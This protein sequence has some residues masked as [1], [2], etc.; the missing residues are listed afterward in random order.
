MSD[1]DLD[2]EEDLARRSLDRKTLLRLA[3]L[4][5]PVWPLLLGVM[6]FATIL[7]M[8]VFTRPY[9]IEWTIDDGLLKQDDGSYLLK[10]D[11]L[12]L[13]CLGLVTVWLGRFLALIMSK[14]FAGIMAF[15]I[16]NDLRQQLFRHVHSLSMRFFDKT[17]VGRIVSRADSDV[18]HLEMAVIEG[19]VV[20]YTTVIRFTLASA[21]LYWY[22]PR[23][24]F[25]LIPI[26]PCMLIAMFLFQKFGT[27]LWAKITEARSRV[28]AHLVETI[29]GIRVIK[30]FAQEQENRHH[31]QDRLDYL[32]LRVRLAAYGW[33][34]FFP[35]LIMLFMCGLCIV[36]WQGGLALQA[37]ELTV[38]EFTTCVFYVF[39]FLGPLADLGMLY[40]HLA[41]GIAS[42][43]RIFL[44]LDT[45]PEVVDHPQAV[46]LAQVTGD[47]VY[48]NVHFYYNP[49][50]WVLHGI[51]LEVPAGQNLAIVGPTGHGKS[52]L[53]QLLAR[54]Y[55]I[56]EG[57][58]TIDGQDI[59][60]VTQQSLHKHVG[61]VLQDN[62]LFSGT[63][64]DNLRLAQPH[65]SDDELIAA[66]RELCADEVIERLPDQY[67]TEVGARGDF[68]SHGQRQLVCL[69]RAY[70]AD[71][72]ILVLDEATSSIDVYTEQ[73]VQ[74]ALWR[75][76]EGRTAI[77]I[78]HRLATIRD[79][80]RIIV[81]NDGR[82]VE[83]G[84]H[85]ELL[86]QSGKYADLYAA[87]QDGD[88]IE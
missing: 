25:A 44:L 75:L 47:I 86:A 40:E 35:F 12:V 17:K 46:P 28:T 80:D 29:G 11:V 67:H 55:D 19:P 21:V 34:W 82:I 81:I 48:K 85:D 39:L 15:R 61:V 38:G 77:I 8:C 27:R 51:N 13:M 79:A 58:I 49:E 56:Q 9:F 20:A 72:A 37:E 88:V 64:L 42:A 65:A 66:C 23:I 4:V 33:S 60:M 71:P 54:F 84:S 24:L 76:C 43:Q 18:N 14:Y 83:S 87:Y 68:I 36:L 45:D 74:K 53:V 7:I 5:R 6:F 73:R 2:V 59:S 16:L 78:A 52:T 57:Q 31:Y 70:L 63:I 3:G 10:Q 69:V 50:E 41:Q 26:I 32:D 30:Q 62:V 1:H 22:S